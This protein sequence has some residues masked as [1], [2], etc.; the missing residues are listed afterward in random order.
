MDDV[1]G[2]KRTIV[3]GSRAA[4]EMVARKGGGVVVKLCEAGCTLPRQKVKY[5]YEDES[6]RCHKRTVIRNVRHVRARG[7]LSGG[8]SGE[9]V[10]NGHIRMLESYCMD[11]EGKLTWYARGEI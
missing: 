2:V 8:M 4:A 5:M 9:A 10:I 6:G 1:Y 3:V 11:A 7:P